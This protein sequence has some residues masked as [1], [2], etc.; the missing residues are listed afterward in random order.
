MSLFLGPFPWIE[1]W[2]WST[3]CLN[4][5][6]QGSQ[7]GDSPLISNLA[8]KASNWALGSM[9]P[10]PS[11][12]EEN[13]RQSHF[14]FVQVLITFPPQMKF[15]MTPLIWLHILG[16]RFQQAAMY[17]ME[18]SRTWLVMS[19]LP[20]RERL[21]FPHAIILPFSEIISLSKFT[22]ALPSHGVKPTWGFHKV[23]LLKI[24]TWGHALGF[25]L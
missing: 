9:I 21:Q 10:R 2:T 8:R 11:L 6:F 1:S 5:S 23:K 4:I 22:D 18:E 25:Q 16:L 24:E 12:E 14:T 13:V 17:H 3:R 19:I 15:H 7:P 20:T